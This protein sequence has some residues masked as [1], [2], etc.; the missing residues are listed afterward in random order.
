VGLDGIRDP[1]KHVSATRGTVSLGGSAG[2]PQERMLT[3]SDT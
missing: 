1:E 2:Q 3:Y